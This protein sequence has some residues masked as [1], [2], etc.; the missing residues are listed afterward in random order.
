MRKT[1]WSLTLAVCAVACVFAQDMESIYLEVGTSR[2]AGGIPFV[3]EKINVIDKRIAEAGMQNGQLQVIGLKAGNTDIVVQGNGGSKTFTVTVIDNRTAV[4]N[5]LKHDFD[6]LPEL[7]VEKSGDKLKIT[8]EINTIAELKLKNKILKAY[9]ERNILDL[10]T[11][12]PAPEVLVHLMN[13][14]KSAGF[15]IVEDKPSE[16]PCELYV[17]RDVQADVIRVKGSV[18]SESQ[19]A[20]VR[21]ILDAE[22][23]LRDAKSKGDGDMDEYK[24]AY[25][26]DIEVK[27]ITLQL[28]VLHIGLTRA[29]C[30]NIG[31]DWE[32]ILS[33]PFKLTASLT[34]GINHTVN[35]S[36]TGAPSNETVYTT[37]K[38]FRMETEEL[39]AVFGLMARNNVNRIRRC[40]FLTIK[41]NGSKD[42][43][44][45]HQGSTVWLQA[46]STTNNNNVS[47]LKEVEYGLIL[48]AKGGMT[49]NGTVKFDLSQT[50]SYPIAVEKESNVTYELKKSTMTTT[51]E[52]RLGEAVAIGGVRERAIANNASGSIPYLRNIPVLRWLVAQDRDEYTDMQILTLISVRRMEGGAA[53]ESINEQLLKMKQEDDEEYKNCDTPPPPTERK[54]YQFWKYMSF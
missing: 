2:Q 36:K 23:W 5:A 37:S 47:E 9:G 33:M 16:E 35:H 48:E 26:M 7:N 8:G 53:M 34:R 39:G 27:N 18:Y 4:L 24:V 10:T 14:L 40:G 19:K 25:Q 12:T 52:C 44:K 29:D 1:V 3:V 49:G 54:W 51:I 13:N 22:P 30:K 45:L 42:P 31:L 17:A 32:N 46:P 41:S 20:R 21:E 15:R 11:F 6:Q 50:V 38:D 28:D 43:S